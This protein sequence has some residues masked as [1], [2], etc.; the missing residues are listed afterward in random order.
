MGKAKDLSGQRFGRLIALEIVGKHPTGS[1]VWRCRCDCG[2]I[3]DVRS[4]DLV[5]GHTKSCGCLKKDFYKDIH[6]NGASHFKDLTGQ[7]FG[8]LVAVKIVDRNVSSGKQWLCHCDCGNDI[9]VSA[10]AL[11]SGNTKSCGCLKKE[12]RNNSKN[13]V[14]NK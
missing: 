8:K 14:D 10:R 13:K 1:V 3:V 2:N 11:L 4:R 12:P 7:R 6:E 9:I 5:R